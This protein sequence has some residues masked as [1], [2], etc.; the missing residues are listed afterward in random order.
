MYRTITVNGQTIEYTLK[1]SKRSRSL[2]I[3]IHP[4]GDVIV[5]VPRLMKF[6][7]FVDNF[8]KRKAEWIL[9]KQEHFKSLGLANFVKKTKSEKRAEYLKNKEVA[10]VL[11][12]KKV[13]EYNKFYN[14][15]IGRIAIRNQR[16]RWGSCSKKG[17]LN[18]NYKL[19]LIPEKLADYIVVHEICHLGEL[20]HSKRFWD[21]VARTI[22][23]HR[24]L[25]AELNKIGINYQ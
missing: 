23:D 2:R 19:A 22:P 24:A 17:N 10:R 5:S 4:D 9:A 7:F 1:I 3:S 20:N 25:R 8:V 11:V 16:T 13:A 14:Y 18:F 12:E 21:L 6:G 15:K